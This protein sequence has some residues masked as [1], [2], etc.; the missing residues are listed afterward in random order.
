MWLW[1]FAAVPALGLGV[2]NY[3]QAMGLLVLSK[4]LFTGIRPK[5]GP[6]SKHKQWKKW[7]EMSSEDREAFKA[8]WKSRKE[9]YLND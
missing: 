5:G 6:N 1:N 2:I 4:I 7:R 9:K 8:R 3:W